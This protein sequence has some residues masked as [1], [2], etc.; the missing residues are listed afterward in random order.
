[1]CHCSNLYHAYNNNLF[2]RYSYHSHYSLDLHNAELQT[3]TVLFTLNFTQG[4][5]NSYWLLPALYCLY[6]CLHLLFAEL[7][8]SK[9]FVYSLS[10]EPYS[11]FIV[12]VDCVF[13]FHV[14]CCVFVYVYLDFSCWCCWWFTCNKL[15]AFVCVV[16]GVFVESA[17]SNCWYSF[18]L[19]F[20]YEMIRGLF[21]IFRD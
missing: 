17:R 14:A 19:L 6:I 4:W 2:I 16:V 8:Q 7:S 12:V 1:M 15:A 18:C 20:S 11:D 21:F 5:L 10:R 3:T 9:M 13:F